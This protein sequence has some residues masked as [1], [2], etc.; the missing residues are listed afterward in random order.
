MIPIWGFLLGTP[1]TPGPPWVVLDSLGT[2]YVCTL[3]V[4]NSSGTSFTVVT[5]VLSSTGAAY[6]PV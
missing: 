4:L 3:T 5:S 2:P 6:N 1:I